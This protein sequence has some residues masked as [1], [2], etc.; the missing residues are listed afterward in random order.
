MHPYLSLLPILLDNYT[1]NRIVDTITKLSEDIEDVVFMLLTDE[2]PKKYPDLVIE[3]LLLH[4]AKYAPLGAHQ[5]I[6]L[7]TIRFLNGYWTVDQY[8][9]E[10]FPKLLS[11]YD[12]LS[13]DAKLELFEIIQS[14]KPA[15][16]LLTLYSAYCL[17]E[18]VGKD[19]H[20]MVRTAGM[21]LLCFLVPENL[22]LNIAGD[23]HSVILL[24]RHLISDS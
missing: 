19:V 9:R 8:V 13:V 12:G 2:V 18:K 16:D 4:L 6:S 15:E 5:V 22:S 21:R 3:R 17:Y 24:L 7:K 20:T 10:I 23:G 11:L 14:Q 1:E